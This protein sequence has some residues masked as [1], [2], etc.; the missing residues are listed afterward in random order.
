[1]EPEIRAYGIAKGFHPQTIRRWLN[2]A[3]ADGSA[4]E[5]IALP[6]KI[7]ENH[8]RDLMD[9]LEEIALRDGV[10]IHSILASK[11]LADIE[12]DPRLG[13]ADKLKRIKDQIRR[14]RFPRLAASEDA[15]LVKIQALKLGPEVRLSVP[16]GL[17]GG[18][19]R[20]EFAASNQEDLKRLTEKLR[21]AVERNCMEDIFKL[22]A[23]HVTG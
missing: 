20:V 17:E 12:T 1:M 18:T 21:Q 4:L 19:L 16:P 5:R 22:L 23:G 15:I 3:P 11:N 2:W 14:L 7:S 9:W 13:R 10:S 8:L 6:L